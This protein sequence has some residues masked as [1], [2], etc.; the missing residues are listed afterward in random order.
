M[1]QT[2]TRNTDK[3]KFTSSD[4][5]KLYRIKKEEHEAALKGDLELT[6]ETARKLILDG[7]KNVLI[8]GPAGSGKTRFIK[9]FFRDHPK[10]A[11]KTLFI[12][13][14]GKA[15]DVYKD[16]KTIHSCF[17][18]NFNVQTPDEICT[19]NS[20][21]IGKDR[22]VIEEI[23]ETRVDYAEQVFKIIDRERK[24]HDRTL[25]VICTGDFSQLSPVCNEDDEIELKKYYKGKYAFHAPSWGHQDFQIIKLHKIERMKAEDEISRKYIDVVYAIKYNQTYGLDWLNSDAISHEADKDGTYICTSNDLVDHYNDLYV[26]QF[27]GTLEIYEPDNKDLLRNRE[28]NIRLAPGMKIMMT[29]NTDKYKNGSMGTITE[30]HDKRVK[31]KLDNND[32]EIFVEPYIYNR[33]TG[34]YEQQLVIAKA[35]TVHKAQGATFSSINITGRFFETGQLYSAL[36]RASSVDGVHILD[37]LIPEDVITDYEAALWGT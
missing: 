15:A 37:P 3:D 29:H 6:K 7:K 23:G 26:D 27:L 28:K 19:N 9:D 8:I 4:F 12:A 17:G 2:Q 31:I 33:D 10:E 21:L 11:E 14:I 16:G 1:S 13:Q 34:Y 32:K 36:T 25:Q 20:A 18:L 22:V 30:T 35:L 24:K 5:A